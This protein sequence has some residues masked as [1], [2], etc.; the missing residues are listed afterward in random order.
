MRY[1]D[2][3]KNDLVEKIINKALEKYNITLQDLSLERQEEIRKLYG[4]E[5]YQLYTITTQEFNEWSKWATV[6]IKFTLKCSMKRA[7]EEFGYLNFNFG[8][9]V[10]DE[11]NP[12]FN[13]DGTPIIVTSP[14]P[15]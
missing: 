8:P 3:K 9:V 6:Q 11:K 14:E 5:W 2:K 13:D 15:Q 12:N 7:A 10:T 4:M 1:N